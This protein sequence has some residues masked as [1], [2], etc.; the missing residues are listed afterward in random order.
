MT[1]ART[2]PRTRAHCALAAAAAASLALGLAALPAEADTFVADGDTIAPGADV[3]LG[4]IPCD[5]PV[6]FDAA[7]T[8]VREG[9]PGTTA[10]FANGATVA[11]DAGTASGMPPGTWLGFPQEWPVIQLPDD[12]T[13]QP[14]GTISQAATYAMS[15]HSTVE[16]PGEATLR[17]YAG[18]PSANTAEDGVFLTAE[19]RVTWTTAGCR[20]NSAPTTPGQVQASTTVTRTGVTLSWAPSVDPDGDPLTYTLETRDQDDAAWGTVI[21]GLT[22]TALTLADPPEGRR[23]YRVTAAEQGQHSPL[24]QSMP[25]TPSATIVVDR[26][27]P[28]APTATT[29]RSPEHVAA[30]GT[31]WWRDNVGI[32]FASAGD[33]KLPDGS[34]GS[35]YTTV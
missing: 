4:E 28:N 31:R 5:Q 33:P 35:G 6:P 32:A 19:H 20:T 34:A 25:G 26:G 21:R 3:A 13:S 30:D 1:T 16:G 27:V 23:A 9:A 7:L 24:L 15:I 12:W 11:F 14:D 2:S 18:G 8:L 29:S 22:G 17:W 10:V